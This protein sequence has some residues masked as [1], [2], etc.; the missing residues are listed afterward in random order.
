MVCTFDSSVANA[1]KFGQIIKCNMQINK[2]PKKVIIDKY[3]AS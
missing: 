3:F 2:R 1:Y